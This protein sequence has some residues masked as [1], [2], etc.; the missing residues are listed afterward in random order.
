M[1]N[2]LFLHRER[3]LE[4]LAGPKLR[5]NVKEWESEILERLHQEHPYLVDSN[6]SIKM[7][8]VDPETGSGIGAVT[9]DERLT[10]P[11]V[12]KNFRLEPLD[13][14]INGPDMLPLTR[15]RIEMALKPLAIGTPVAPGKGEVTDAS[16]THMTTPPYDGKY[17]F[18]SAL[19]YTKDDFAGAISRAFSEDGL[20]FEISTNG[21]LKE[22]LL[23][24][25]SNAKEEEPTETA[26]PYSL[27]ETA[28]SQQSTS[29][30]GIHSVLT[31]K[32]PVTGVL[33]KTASGSWMFVGFNGQYVTF[34]KQP[35]LPL[36]DAPIQKMASE[37]IRG[38]GVFIYKTAS[39]IEASG[40]FKVVGFVADDPIIRDQTGNKYTLYFSKEASGLELG[41]GAAVINEDSAFMPL[42]KKT[43]IPMVKTAEA[44]KRGVYLK[45]EKR[46]G[47]VHLSSN[48]DW[49]FSEALLKE[50]EYMEDL[51]EKLSP[52]FDDISLNKVAA[53][54]GT[55]YFAV[56]KN[57]KPNARPLPEIEISKEA[58][59]ALTKTASLFD[60]ASTSFIKLSEEGSKKTIDTLLGLNFLTKQNVSKFIENMDK[61]AEARQAVGQLLMASRLGL[62]VDQ[63]PIKA[64]FYALDEVE[65]D[66]QQLYNVTTTRS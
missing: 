65:Q 3:W 53:V 57:D 33:A 40:P 16:L 1:N 51:R 26:P 20:T 28:V 63:G 43:T 17:T 36:A 23:A 50:G 35:E 18:A 32:G 37:K 22:A 12:V 38:D 11:I 39:G 8:K 2:N 56:R 15:A 21:I 31:G 61:I 13:T 54:Q 64:A 14:L 45:I 6:I 25:N 7:K 59:R 55:Q 62:D 41:E 46:A 24:F 58:M 47:R 52:Y 27:E 34:D 48:K 4:K 19:K 66:L 30:P 60:A 49:E 44:I 29:T 10:I 9:L 42:L 5:Q